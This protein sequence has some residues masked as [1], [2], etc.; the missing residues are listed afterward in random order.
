MLLTPLQPRSNYGDNNIPEM[1]WFDCD[2]V[3]CNC[4]K[5]P[6]PGNVVLWTRRAAPDVPV[7]KDDDQNLS[8]ESPTSSDDNSMVDD[9]F[10]EEL[11]LY[12]KYVKLKGCKYHEQ[13]QTVLKSFRLTREAGE[14]ISLRQLFEPAN[15][16]DENA[17]V[18]QVKLP[19]RH[20]EFIGYIPGKK[21]EKSL[22]PYSLL[23]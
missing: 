2:T 16:A 18:A 8:D 10:D 7:E 20:W 21:V 3:I 6:Q 13:F 5:F 11:P 22:V 17:V 15:V 4:S 12:T 9:N 23:L 19:G 1:P 14:D